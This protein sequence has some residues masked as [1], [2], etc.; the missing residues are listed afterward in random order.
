MLPP[1]LVYARAL[2]A[3]LPMQPP[4][5]LLLQALLNAAVSAVCAAG[6]KCNV[7]PS[8]DPKTTALAAVLE[9]NAATP[10]AMLEPLTLNVPALTTRAT[11]AFAS[12]GMLIDTAEL[13]MIV[14]LPGYLVK[15]SATVSP[16]NT[17]LLHAL[18]T[19]AQPRIANQ[20]LF[21]SDTLSSKPR[22]HVKARVELDESRVKSSTAQ[23]A[24]RRVLTLETVQARGA[25]QSSSASSITSS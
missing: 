16:L 20:F 14:W 21:I 4:L 8:C 7:K 22:L 5:P 11:V 2:V 6:V 23:R 18:K 24:Q 13:L 19:E 9:V 17:P 15:T 12:S 1:A 10:P 25:R 3:A